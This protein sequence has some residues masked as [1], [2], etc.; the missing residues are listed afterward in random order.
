VKKVSGERR[1]LNMKNKAPA[2]KQ[3]AP[4]TKLMANPVLGTESVG[5]IINNLLL[6]CLGSAIVAVALNGIIIPHKFVSGGLTGLALS[7]HYLFPFLPVSWLYFFMNI[8]LFIIGWKFVGRRFFYYSIAGTI[9]FSAMVGWVYV[10]LQIEDKI[11]SA[12]FAGILT[13]VGAG[14]ILKSKGSAGGTDI[15]SVVLLNRFSVRVGNTILAFN[16]IVLTGASILF[17]LESALYTMVYMYV[18]SRITELVL[19][20][21]SQ[22]KAVIII[23]PKWEEISRKILNEIVRGVTFIKGRGAYSGKDENILYTVITFRELPRVKDIV[24]ETDP[25]AFVVV[26]ETLE[27]IGHRIGNQ[28]H[29]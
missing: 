26:H 7:I 14:I 17:S 4:V 11:L 6:I 12:L 23:S 19:T 24:K 10:P 5:Q 1:G 28:P 8:P 20:G 21:L 3:S 27:V 25:D 15:L 22:R 16:I 2:K 29:W 13:G 9:I 18:A